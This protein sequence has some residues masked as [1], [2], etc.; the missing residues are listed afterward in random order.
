[1]ETHPALGSLFKFKNYFEKADSPVQKWPDKLLYICRPTIDFEKNK[2][3]NVPLEPQIQNLFQ[4]PG[5]V[6]DIQ[7]RF[8]RSKKKGNNVEDIYDGAIYTSF[9]Q[10]GEPLS[11]SYPYN[12]SFCLNTD[13][14]P[15]FKSSK[16]SI[17]PVYLMINE[18]EYKLRRQKENM[19]FCGLWCGES[20]PLFSVFSRPFLH[21]LKNLEEQG[22][23]VQVNEKKEVCKGFVLSSTA[24]LPAKSA[25]MNMVQYNGKHGCPN[26]LQPGQNFRTQSG[27]NI[28]VS[29]YDKNNPAGTLRSSEQ[30]FNDAKEALAQK[31]PVNGVKGPSFLMGLRRYKFILGTSI[32]YMHCV[33]LGIT[34][35]LLSLWFSSRN[36]GKHFS[37]LP[38]LDLI[39]WC[40]LKIKPPY[41][42]TRVPRAIGSNFKFWKAS[43]LRSWL[44]F[45]SLPL[46]FELMDS[47][48][49]CHYAAFVE[50]IHILT[51]DSIAPGDIERS[52]T[53]LK[54]FVFMMPSIYRDVCA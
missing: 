21:S 8:K 36:S 5:F 6:D 33:L 25:L 29:P 51:K 35:C 11:S 27:G 45:Y 34:K 38:H 14:I 31:V 47:I 10:T 32:D 1:M 53:L 13:G 23:T 37:L 54:Y 7:H 30:S 44:L 28:H 26:C 41:L 42:V 4:R 20:K 2:F 22:V 40:L 9:S 18:L 17:W 50:S 43:Q 24:D 48:Q 15:V 52:N 3:L 16:V 12:I 39:D 49:F 46:L 19:L